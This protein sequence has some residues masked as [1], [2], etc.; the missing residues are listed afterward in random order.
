MNDFA[1]VPTP[2][3]QRP[4]AP[5]PDTARPQGPAGRRLEDQ[6]FLLMKEG[7]AASGGLCGG[8]LVARRMRSQFDQ[9][10][11]MLARWIVTRQAVNILWQSQWML[12]LF[13]FDPATMG[14]CPAV[15]QV[16]AELSDVFDDWDLALWFVQRNAWL[17]GQAP[18]TVIATDAPAVRDAARA[19]RFVARG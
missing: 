7:F 18:V 3:R 19:D 15:K 4:A 1:M 10:I 17:D 14:V 8:D 16:L 9:P 13:Q 12:P 11:S 2:L 5:R 6:Q